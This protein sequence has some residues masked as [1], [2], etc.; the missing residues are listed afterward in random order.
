MNTPDLIGLIGLAGCLAA[1]AGLQLGRLQADDYAY[2]GLNILGPACLLYSLM[3]DFNL[4]A[5]ITQI[6]WMSLSVLG[7]AK[8]MS[9]RRRKTSSVTAHC[10]ENKT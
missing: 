8:T 6:T 2:I 7:L 3:H 4:A 9:A 5:V 1:Y 10:A